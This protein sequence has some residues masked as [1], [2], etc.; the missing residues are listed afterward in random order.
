MKISI[1]DFGTGYSSL[2]YLK[3]LP[4]DSLKIDKIFIDNIINDSTIAK[5]IIN[6]AQSLELSLIAEGVETKEQLRYL[7]KIGCQSIQGY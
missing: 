3:K 7:I 5:T 6:M 2:S 4:I 1:D